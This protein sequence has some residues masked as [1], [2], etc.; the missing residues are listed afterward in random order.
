MVAFHKTSINNMFY[1]LKIQKGLATLLAFVLTEFSYS[2][3]VLLVEDNF[4][5]TVVFF[6]SEK[7]TKKGNLSI[8]VTASILP[9]ARITRDE[10]NYKLKSR[11][12]SSYGLG[13]NYLY[14]INKSIAVTSGLHFIVGK[15]NFFLN[16][17]SEDISQ[18]NLSGHLIIEDKELWGAFW[19]P[20][21]LEKKINAKKTGLISLKTGLNLRYSGLMTDLVMSGGGII[22]SNNQVISIFSA[23]FSGNNN[24]K[25][26]I[27]FLA[28]VSKLFV[29]DNHNVLSVGLQADISPTYFLKGDY[30]ITIPNKPVT[31]GTYKISGTSLGLS[32]QYIFTGYNKRT[33]RSYQKKGF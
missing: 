5:D 33:V 28:G 23:F 20:L 31:S 9:K 10:G 4:S 24:Y 12:Q 3:H 7:S 14:D 6:K 8:E 21:Q 17:P 25:P 26:W 30:E 1:C 13:I 22:D 32:V 2:Q 15:R 11:I 27:T 29:L 16:I 19:I 18:Y